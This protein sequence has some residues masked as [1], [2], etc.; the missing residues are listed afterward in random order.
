MIPNLFF[1][2]LGPPMGQGHLHTLTWYGTDGDDDGEG[3]DVVDDDC[4]DDGDNDGW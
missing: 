3:D 1:G 2:A 4:D